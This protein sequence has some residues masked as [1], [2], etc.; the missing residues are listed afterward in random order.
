MSNFTFEM[1]YKT[2][3][4]TYEWDNV[5]WEQTANKDA[6]RVLYIG[7]SIS[8]GTRHKATAVANGKYLFDGFGTSKALDNPFFKDALITFAKQM[9]R[10]DIIV[11][12][13][14]LHGFHLNEQEYTALYRDMLL[15]LK[16]NFPNTPIAVVLTTYVGIEETLKVAELRN[17]RVI[18]LAEELNLPIIDFYT[19]SKE[20]K[21]LLIEDK[22][23]FSEAGYE[24]LAKYM[25]KRINEIFSL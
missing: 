18:N 12:N 2:P 1:N 17:K 11:I 8:C 24:I 25:I 21:D 5:W 14:G 13:N 9:S 10:I 6:K 23:H 7:D 4:E 22:V 3:L 16:E 15:F 20:N 19:V